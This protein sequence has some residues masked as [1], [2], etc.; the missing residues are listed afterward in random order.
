MLKKF[1][2]AVSPMLDMTY[3]NEEE[4]KRLTELRDGILPKLMLGE[5]YVS[6]LD[7][8]LSKL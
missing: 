5:L 6:Y 4:N 8:Y 2:D 1:D 3:Q 7:I